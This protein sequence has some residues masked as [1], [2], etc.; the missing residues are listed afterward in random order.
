MLATSA[1]Q[2]QKTQAA[3]SSR[4][5]DVE[6]RKQRYERAAQV[7]KQSWRKSVPVG[8]NIGALEKAWKLNSNHPIF[9]RLSKLDENEVLECLNELA[10]KQKE[11][12]GNEKDAPHDNLEDDTLDSGVFLGD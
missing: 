2:A 11:L 1:D 12:N 5:A 8:V 6:D 4:R 10:I 7:Q 3:L 9:D